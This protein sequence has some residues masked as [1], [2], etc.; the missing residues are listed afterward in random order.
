MPWQVSSHC[1]FL[2]PGNTQKIL[3]EIWH[4]FW[5]KKRYLLTCQANSAFLGRFFCTGQQQL[6]RPLWNFKIIFS[7]PVFTIIFMPKMVTN[8]HRIF[9]CI[10]W[11]QKPTTWGVESW[12]FFVKVLML[13]DIFCYIR[14]G[15]KYGWMFIT[16]FFTNSID[17]DGT[18]KVVTLKG[19]R[20]P[21]WACLRGRVWN[22]VCSGCKEKKEDIMFR[23]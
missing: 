17:D 9:L 19:W 8:I 21:P 16:H 18:K 5:L 7:R 3:M 2:V 4:H 20:L 23:F 22:E 14:F 11:H 15:K 1:R 6:W 10:V 12:S 13:K